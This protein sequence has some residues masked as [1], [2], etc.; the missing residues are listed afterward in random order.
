MR[1]LFVLLWCVGVSYLHGGGGVYQRRVRLWRWQWMYRKTRT[2]V[3]VDICRLHVVLRHR[4]FYW[5]IL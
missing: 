2:V 3:K 1:I 4:R 5:I